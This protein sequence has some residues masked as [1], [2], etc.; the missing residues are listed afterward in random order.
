MNP[1][2]QGKI[3]NFCAAY[4]VLN[5]LRLLFG[6]SAFQARDILNDMLIEKAQNS[7]EWKK[8]VCHETDYYDLV[9]SM[10]AK[11]KEVYNY[12]YYRP[13][14]DIHPK[15]D[16]I[17]FFQPEVDID[18]IWE[19]LKKTVVLSAEANKNVTA[20][21]RFCRFLPRQAGPIVDHWSTISRVTDT[22]I[23]LYDCSLETTG[24]Y[25]LSRDKFFSA[26]F[27]AVPPQRIA[28][29]QQYMLNLAE[30]EFGVICPESIFM[31]EK[32]KS[33]FETIAARF[34][35]KIFDI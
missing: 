7:E 26:P 16:N 33:P 4:S 11:W 34:K 31:I 30:E 24:W 29:Q 8:I 18:T 25:V 9:G 20:V 23:Y 15:L 14:P 22:E 5:A 6:I 3:D 2:F 35:Q 10:L 12:N 21:F 32:Q 1:L 19:F 17:R 27:G 13:F 28:L